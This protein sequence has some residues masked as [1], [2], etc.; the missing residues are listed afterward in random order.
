MSEPN[1]TTAVQAGASVEGKVAPSPRTKVTAKTQEAPTARPGE[2]TSKAT[3]VPTVKVSH[4]GLDAEAEIPAK[5][6][7]LWE[8]SGWVAQEGSESEVDAEQPITGETEE[9]E[10]EDEGEDED[11]P[12]DAPE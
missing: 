5:S 1:D 11:A 7:E 10:G 12:G 8:A 3:P 2:E 4:P 6:L 9:D